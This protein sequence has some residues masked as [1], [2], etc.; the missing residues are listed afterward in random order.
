MDELGVCLIGPRTRTHRSHIYVLDLP[1]EEW[2]QYFADQK[3]RVSPERDGI[4]VSFGLFNSME[5]VEQL[6]KIIE[7]RLAM[8]SPTTNSVEA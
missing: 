1:A 4:R 3:V 5:D 2:L 7:V 8:N 6:A